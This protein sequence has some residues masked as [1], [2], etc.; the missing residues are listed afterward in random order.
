MLKAREI[1]KNAENIVVIGASNNKIKAAHRIPKYLQDTG[2]NV[3]PVN[4]N[5]DEVLGVKSYK[6]ISEIP[7]DIKIDIVDIFRPSKDIS[8]LMPEIIKRFKKV[9]DIKLV[10]LQEGIHSK[11]AKELCKENGIEFIQG[12]CIYKVH[13]SI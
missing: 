6:S 7:E 2:Y 1:L 10:W 5:S 9:K 11:E 13:A 3:I 12:I 8:A 4:P